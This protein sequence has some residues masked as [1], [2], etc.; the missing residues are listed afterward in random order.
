MGT[1]QILLIVLSVIIVGV[2]VAVGITMFATQATNSNRQALVGEL[3]NFGAAAMQYYKTPASQG[4]GGGSAVV[5][6]GADLAAAQAGVGVAMGF[7]A[8][9]TL[10]DDT[11]TFTL[12]W[13]SATVITISA[14]GTEKTKAGDNVSALMTV[15][16][17]NA[18]PMSTSI[19]H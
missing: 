16:A 13:T 19:V 11:G 12:G 1:Q 2:A 9:G 7:A 6:F 18:S 3:Q 5:G 8:D 15:N 10:T 14:V 4:G 17:A